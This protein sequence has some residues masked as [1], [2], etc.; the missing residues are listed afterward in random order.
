MFLAVYCH[1]KDFLLLKPV[2]MD[3]MQENFGMKYLGVYCLEM[4]LS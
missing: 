4:T 2:V 3:D 1:H